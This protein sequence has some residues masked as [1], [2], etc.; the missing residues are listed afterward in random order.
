MNEN[1]SNDIITKKS[2]K[3]IDIDRKAFTDAVSRIIEFTELYAGIK[4]MIEEFR[5]AIYEKIQSAIHGMKETLLWLAEHLMHVFGRVKKRKESEVPYSSCLNA[6]IAAKISIIC[7]RSFMIGFKE[8]SSRIRKTYLLRSQDRG[9][10]DKAINV[11][12]FAVT[13]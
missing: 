2:D 7:A 10:S 9:C 5:A 8:R 12:S 13:C 1:A 11:T 3:T 6:L 4:K